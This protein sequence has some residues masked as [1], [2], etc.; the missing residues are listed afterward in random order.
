MLA[1]THEDCRAV[2]CSNEFALYGV[3]QMQYALRKKLIYAQ[4]QP[5]TQTTAF[6][7]TNNKTRLFVLV[8][9]DL[10]R[11]RG[12]LHQVPRC[13]LL[14]AVLEGELCDT[15]TTREFTS[16]QYLSSTFY[17]GSSRFTAAWFT[18]DYTTQSRYVVHTLLESRVF[19]IENIKMM[20]TIP[21]KTAH[22]EDS[23]IIGCT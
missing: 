23:N 14:P 19:I 13:L 3:P 1:G 7:R 15:S 17:Y 8:H 12:F 6:K 20:M 21:T 22:S 5:Y 9:T 10:A 18:I 2:T 4:T 11:L 16:R